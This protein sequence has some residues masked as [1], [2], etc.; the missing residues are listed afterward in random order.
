[1]SHFQP[2]PTNG[3]FPSPWRLR[4]ARIH[5][6]RLLAT[7]PVKAFQLCLAAETMDQLTVPLPTK[8]PQ[9]VE[10]STLVSGRRS[11]T[12]VMTGGNR[13]KSRHGEC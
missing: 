11:L 5:T 12:G 3:G 7:R 2:V 13:E 1:M 8:T 10:K 4:L 9:M 6:S